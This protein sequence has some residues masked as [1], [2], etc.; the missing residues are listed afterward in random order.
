MIVPIV[1][2]FY[3]LVCVGVVLFNCWKVVSEKVYRRSFERRK[4]DDLRWLEDLMRRP[5][6]PTEDEQAEMVEKMTRSLRSNHAVL[7]FHAA[8]EEAEKADPKAFG[9]C[10][11]LVA[12]VIQRLYPF[13]ADRSA[14]KQAYYSFL[15]TRFQMM[16]YAPSERV[17]AYLLE[18]IRAAKSLY[19]LENALR[20]VYSSGQLSLVLRA[21]RAL[22]GKDGILLHEK[23]LVDGLLTFDDREA[24]IAALWEQLPLCS[25][26]MCRLLLDYIRFASGAWGEQMLSLLERTDELELRI[27]CLRYL[28]KYPDERFRVSIYQLT[29]ES[30]SAEW[31][32]CAVCMT[33]LAAYP[34]DE[35][36]RLLKQG[37]CSPSWYVRYN[38]ALSLR[39]LE[40]GTEQL[41]D[42]L[43]GDDR[44]A[45][46]MLQ[47]RLGLTAAA[48]TEKEAV[49]V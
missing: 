39:V 10:L 15:V 43:T 20:A 25:T 48:E 7:A 34:G 24:L 46:E 5:V 6:P 17:T 28:G 4:K 41:Q 42:I 47:Y 31:E 49:P 11:P 44:Y 12:E 35:T 21:L 9:P 32:L 14:Q 1:L 18:Q 26:Q 33:A 19:N 2:G 40:V 37:L 8:M 23:L 29:E 38:A 45:R 27:A 30:Q 16:K 22:D 3:V 13:Y 36:L